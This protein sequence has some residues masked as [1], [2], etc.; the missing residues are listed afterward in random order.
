VLS[1]L[2]LPAAMS[3]TS[4]IAAIGG[5]VP[6]LLYFSARKGNIRTFITGNKRK[7]I[8]VIFIT[9]LLMA[10]DGSGMYLLKK[11]SADGRFLTWKIGLRSA[12]RH[13]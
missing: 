4:W 10:A 6:V 5:C 3:R 9:I 2:V 8:L 12:V 7:F 1:I 11:D 13:P